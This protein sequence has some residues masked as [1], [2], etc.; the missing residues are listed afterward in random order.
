MDP[1]VVLVVLALL[2]T[3]AVLLMGLTTLA[4]PSL[5]GKFGTPMMWMRVG[6]QGLTI[7]LLFIALL[8]R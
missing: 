8:L 3:V 7:L 4:G 2:A 1:F 6:L 5:D